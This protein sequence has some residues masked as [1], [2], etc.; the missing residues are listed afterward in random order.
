MGNAPD[1]RGKKDPRFEPMGPYAPP[2][3]TEAERTEGEPMA[4]ANDKQTSHGKAFLPTTQ[5]KDAYD[6]EVAQK[7]A[8]LPGSAQP[9]KDAV[10][11][12]FTVNP[13]DAHERAGSPEAE[14]PETVK[15][16]NDPPGFSEVDERGFKRLETDDAG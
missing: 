1:K 13:R 6:P 15:M 10:Q 8:F 14:K 12:S 4:V 11:E 9:G 5:S 16:E 7:W 2:L 3:P